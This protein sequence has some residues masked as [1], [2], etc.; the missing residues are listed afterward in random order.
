M[1]GP[2]TRAM[3]SESKAEDAMRRPENPKRR[4]EEARRRFGWIRVGGRR[5]NAAAGNIRLSEA[6][7]ASGLVRRC[8]GAAIEATGSLHLAEE[9]KL[10]DLAERPMGLAD[11][12]ARH[13]GRQVG[14]LI[15]R[16]ALQQQ[17]SIRRP[18]VQCLLRLPA[19]R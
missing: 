11:R 2:G 14:R 1:H 16:H 10:I 5:E 18:R 9:E 4:R 12:N 8:F 15:R 13:V 7:E 19:V 6:D 3:V 17:R